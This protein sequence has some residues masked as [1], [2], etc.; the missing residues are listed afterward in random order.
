MATSYFQPKN[1][2]NEFRVAVSAGKTRLLEATELLDLC[3]ILGLV[4]RH[5]RRKRSV[6]EFQGVS[7]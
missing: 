1:V 4:C 7:Y 3:D 2:S 5:V 6:E